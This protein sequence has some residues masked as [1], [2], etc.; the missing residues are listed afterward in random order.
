MWDH[1]WILW[2]LDEA[3]ARGA[4]AQR[5]PPPTALPRGGASAAPHARA[6]RTAAAPRGDDW[7]PS[8]RPVGVPVRRLGPRR[9]D[10]R[11]VATQTE[12][13]GA[14][15]PPLPEAGTPSRGSPAASAA[16]SSGEAGDATPAARSRGRRRGRRAPGWRR[17]A[18]TSAWSLM[19]WNMQRAGGPERL[20]V[21]VDESASCATSAHRRVGDGL[22]AVEVS[23]RFMVAWVDAQPRGILMASVHAPDAWSADGEALSSF[24]MQPADGVC[25]LMAK[26]PQNVEV[27]QGGD[28]NV[29]VEE[30]SLGAEPR[31][32]A[33]LGFMDR[34]GLAICSSGSVAWHRP[35]DPATSG[36]ELDFLLVRG[37]WGAAEVQKTDALHIR[38]DHCPVRLRRPCLGGGSP[39]DA[40][41]ALSAWRDRLAARAG[42]AAAS[43]VGAHAV[44][45]PE[46]GTRQ[47]PVDRACELCH[48][49]SAHVYRHVAD[50]GLGMGGDGV[51]YRI[52]SS[53]P[54][55]DPVKRLRAAFDAGAARPDLVA[56][57][58]AV[59][60]ARIR[61]RL[62]RRRR[63]LWGA[64]C[65][66]GPRGRMLPHALEGE[67]DRARWLTLLE[68]AL[69]FC[70]LAGCGRARSRG[71]REMVVLCAGVHA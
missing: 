59:W 62:L 2:S 67:T 42:R 29:S 10:A 22:R 16:S 36:K 44:A 49:V 19:T 57:R 64:V 65:R 47:L 32:V 30:V 27:A 25:R 33:M 37:N 53:M 58:R 15:Q 8:L 14:S 46:A 63:R 6:S 45:W 34:L 24:L 43:P 18:G 38:S 60:R 40:G 1:D 13:E 50:G 9:V 4:A 35:T 52:G 48:D 71:S 39:R 69:A 61:L 54:V 11:D 3:A 12:A 70:R 55:A 31:V 5:E 28:W 41:A 23:P 51:D 56:L 20:A 21:V 17:M 66:A 68:G 7:R 26:A